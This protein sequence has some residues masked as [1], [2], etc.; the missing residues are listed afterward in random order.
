M[1]SKAFI[2]KRDEL[3]QEL[4]NYWKIMHVHNVLNKNYERK[5]N[6]KEIYN[7][8]KSLAKERALVKLKL[9]AINLGLKKFSDL[10]ADCNQFNI[11]R[12][13]ELKELKKQLGL[14]K[15][16]NPVLKAKKGKKGLNR[17]EE[18]TANWIKARIKE[19]DLEILELSEKLDKFNEE[20]EFDDECAPMLL[21][22]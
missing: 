5:Y 8:I 3:S 21:A 16:I 10:P 2:I 6:L 15:T 9:Q 19:L 7:T 11:F 12:L 14:V 4:T 18:L 22:A 17:T 13:G 1:K 20:T